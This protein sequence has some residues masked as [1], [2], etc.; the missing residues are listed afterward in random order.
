MDELYHHGIKG[1]KWGIRRF[2]KKDGSYTSAGKNRRKNQTRGWSKDA[3]EA[4]RIGQ[5]NVKQMSN[6]ELK[7]LNERKR[8]ESEYSRL[9][10]STIKKGANFVKVV[11]A[12]TG[13]ALTIYNN[14]DKIVA[15]GK[16][17]ANKLQHS[18]ISEDELYHFGIKGMKWGVRRYQNKDGTLTPKGKKRYINDDGSLTKSG[19]RLKKKS[20]KKLNRAATKVE[21]SAVAIE[22]ITDFMSDQAA[23]K[24]AKG[25]EYKGFAYKVNRQ[26]ALNTAKYADK[27][28]EKGYRYATTLNDLN[29]K[30]EARPKR[31]TYAYGD[32]YYT[33]RGNEY[34]ERPTSN[35]GKTT[36]KQQRKQAAAQNRVKQMQSD[37]DAKIKQGQQQG[38]ISKGVKAVAEYDP[39]SNKYYNTFIYEDGTKE[40]WSVG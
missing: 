37:L 17:F 23:R 10:P 13:T 30:I 32:G 29:V 22:D 26:T 25:K 9:N 39:K 12:A 21:G 4:N 28:S 27:Q 38:K 20:L 11:A 35:G 18:D 16:R 14:S 3:K 36:S 24:A 1:Q 34:V 19:N 2:Q 8:L 7:R 15:A 33:F 6:A 31:K 40:R 5:K